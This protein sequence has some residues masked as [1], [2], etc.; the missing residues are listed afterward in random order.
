MGSPS[1]PSVHDLVARLLAE[2]AT[3]GSG[4]L[5]CLDGP[6]GSGKTT[7][8]ARVAALGP[9]GGGAAAVIHLDD[10]YDG[11]SGLPRLGE[12]LATLLDPLAR[13]EPGT[14]RRYDWE[15]A[16]YAETVTVTPVPLLVLEGVGSGLAA[17]APV[18]T[19]LVWVEAPPKLRLARWRARDGAAAEP[20]IAAW[21]RDEEALFAKEDTRAAADL[22]WDPSR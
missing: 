14:Y 1:E 7:L 4:R 12:Q 15:R 20:F 6:A 3:L 9:F 5:L 10:L 17:Y 2:P 8:A 18:R 16:R 13:D 11:W 21:Q 19:L 22:V